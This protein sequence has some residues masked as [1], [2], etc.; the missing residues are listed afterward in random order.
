MARAT[1]QERC[2]LVRGHGATCCGALLREA[3]F[4]SI[5]IKENADLLLRTL[6]LGEPKYLAPGEIDQAR[7]ML[8]EMPQNRTWDY[9]LAP[10]G[11]AGL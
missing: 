6:P 10:A 8:S 4:V 3:V 11:F 9:R 5:Y 7:A 2:V 1:G